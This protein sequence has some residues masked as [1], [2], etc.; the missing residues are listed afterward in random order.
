M[1]N[2]LIIEI[3]IAAALLFLAIRLPISSQVRQWLYL[4]SSYA[5]YIVVGRWAICFLILSTVGNF[6]LGKLLRARLNAA[7]LWLGVIINILF[8]SFF[9][10]LPGLLP[11]SGGTVRGELIRIAMPLGISFW[12]FQ[13]L[14]YLFDIYREEELDLNLREFALYMTFAPT[15]LSGPICRLGE[16]LP[17]FRDMKPA[18]WLAV[19][20]GLQRI[21]LGVFGRDFIRDPVKE[22]PPLIEIK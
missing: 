11:P 16:M 3:A 10:Y 6:G 9:K 21:W 15:V 22:Q 19:R 14:S 1:S 2:L 4:L 17:Q 5:F 8:L 7:T 20:G 12:T 18:S 13:A